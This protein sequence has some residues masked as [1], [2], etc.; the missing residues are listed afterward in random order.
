[1]T[2]SDNHPYRDNQKH[3][4]II[5][6]ATC[7]ADADAAIE[8]AANLARMVKG[9]VL[10][11]L[12]EDDSI[13]D[14]ADLPFAKI[15]TFQHGKVQPVTRKTMDSAFQRDARN[16]ERRLANAAEQIA[17]KW[18][19]ERK[20]GQ[21]MPLLHSAASAGDFIFLGYKK[22]GLPR[23]EIVYI[24]FV[25][26]ASDPVLDLSKAISGEMR[27]GLKTINLSEI[28]SQ[29]NGNITNTLNYLRKTSPTA[30]IVVTDNR[31]NLDLLDILETA[32]CPVIL[33]VQNHIAEDSTLG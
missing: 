19:F 32:R 28:E 21:M 4:R 12:V 25:G 3:R 27:L 5:V 20:R 10:G 30:V 17:V 33:S 22:T 24:D 26:K 29:N 8:M 16:F 14:Y 9:E 7:F 13:L 2:A 23:G 11:L 31:H 1:M 6:G 18:S 15:L